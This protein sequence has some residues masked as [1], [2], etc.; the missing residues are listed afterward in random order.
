MHEHPTAGAGV[1][2]A[3]GG[4]RRLGPGHGI[5]LPGGDRRVDALETAELPGV[6]ER[7]ELPGAGRPDRD[8][9]VA[10]AAQHPAHEEQ[11]RVEDD[12]GVGTLDVLEEGAVGR[13][14][15]VIEG[16]EDDPAARAHGR[17]LGGDL[18]PGDPHLAA[19]AG[20]E[21]VA[22][23]GDPESAQQGR[24]ELHDVGRDVEAEH[25]E[26]GAHPLGTGH[27]GQPGPGHEARAVAEVEGELGRLGVGGHD[28]AGGL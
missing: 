21:Q 9:A 26:L 13:S 20:A 12:P 18:D 28:L 16:E 25:V 23:A 3:R 1:L 7:G 24:V 11:P 19:A 6:P 22:A 2:L 8:P 14:G 15:G 17:G 5:G 10:G 4:L 27:L